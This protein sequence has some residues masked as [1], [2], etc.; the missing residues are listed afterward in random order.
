VVGNQI[1]VAPS[2]TTSYWYQVQDSGGCL[3]NGGTSTVS[4]CI[5]HI[6]QQPS[7]RTITAGSA[8]TLSVV[9]DLPAATYQW[10][11]GAAGNT[12]SP[13]AGGTSAAL[14]VSPT[15]TR[16]YWV[17]VSGPCGQSVDS[18]AVTVTVAQPTAI[19][20]QPADASIAVPGTAIFTVAA[21][22]T[23][24]AYQWYRGTAGNTS[25]PVGD[26]T[27]TLVVTPATPTDYWV[28]VTGA[29]GMSNSRTAHVSAC[30]TPG[31]TT[32]PQGSTIFSGT[33]A[34]LTAAAHESTGEPLHYQWYAGSTPSA[35]IRRPTPLR[36]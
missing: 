8:T 18:D 29:A 3:S 34:T 35:R 2:V 6:T 30:T 19:L 20:T 1:D 11:T 26:N 33:A 22:G 9:S 23:D 36:L 10:Y 13:V 31:I 4:V 24:L 5:P 32:Q 12:A 7:G 16:D 28:R 14:T 21:T 27:T 25:A 15:A 17:R